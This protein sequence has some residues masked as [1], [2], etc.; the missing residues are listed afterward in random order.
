MTLLQ[1]IPGGENYGNGKIFEKYATHR[2][3]VLNNFKTLNISN[4]SLNALLR[5]RTGQIKNC[6]WDS[7]IFVPDFESPWKNTQFFF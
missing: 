3:Y 2:K 5:W 4:L 6:K 7:I 1:S